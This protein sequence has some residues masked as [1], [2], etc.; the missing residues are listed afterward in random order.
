MK[1]LIFVLCM[2]ICSIAWCDSHQIQSKSSLTSSN[3]FNND[4][5][6][7]FD[8]HLGDI[9]FVEMFATT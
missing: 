4:D 8:D 3:I 9:I 5:R 2:L 7:T 1:N 6:T